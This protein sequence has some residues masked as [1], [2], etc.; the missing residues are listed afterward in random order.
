MVFLR[1]FFELTKNIFDAGPKFHRLSQN[2]N[3][4]QKTVRSYKN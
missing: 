3:F 4:I 1:T 2:P